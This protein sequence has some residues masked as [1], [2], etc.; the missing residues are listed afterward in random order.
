MQLHPAELHYVD[1]HSFCLHMWRPQT[2]EEI[3]EIKAKWLADGDKWPDEYP[4][5]GAVIPL[6]PPEMVGPKTR[7]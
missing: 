7:R 6:P 4:T 1:F 3:L 5:I 2:T